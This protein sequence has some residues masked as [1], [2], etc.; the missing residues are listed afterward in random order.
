MPAHHD[1]YDIFDLDYALGEDET[2]ILSSCAAIEKMI[3][4]ETASG[5]PATRI[6]LAGFSQGGAMSLL[7][8]LISD[9]K[10]AGLVNLSGRL[11]MQGKL[12][13]VSRPFRKEIGT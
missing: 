3:R 13:N 11:L 1:R 5:I 4:Q 10:L 9:F 12:S 8:G 2:G 7:A 6:V